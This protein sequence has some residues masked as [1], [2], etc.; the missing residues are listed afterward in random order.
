MKKNNMLNKKNISKKCLLVIYQRKIQKQKLSE[1]FLNQKMKNE[2]KEF[3]KYH[4]YNIQRLLTIYNPTKFET[5]SISTNN[6]KAP[7]ILKENIN[8]Y[9]MNLKDDLKHLF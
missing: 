9:Y 7:F 1:K 4:I 2:A 6:G 5:M 3:I 8:N